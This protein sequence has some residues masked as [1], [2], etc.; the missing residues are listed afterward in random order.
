MCP[1]INFEHQP[2]ER[3]LWQFLNWFNRFKFI[4]L[5]SYFT[6]QYMVAIVLQLNCY[7]LGDSWKKQ[8]TLYSWLIL[9]KCHWECILCWFWSAERKNPTGGQWY[10]MV[11]ITCLTLNVWDSLQW[12][13]LL[14]IMAYVC[15]SSPYD[16]T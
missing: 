15:F 13:F 5:G 12:N 9:S 8:R 11:D 3:S 7:T 6:V 16:L 14:L 1:F 4:R 10:P 2:L